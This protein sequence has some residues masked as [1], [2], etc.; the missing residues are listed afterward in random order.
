MSTPIQKRVSRRANVSAKVAEKP[1][2]WQALNEPAV[3]LSEGF[4]KD[5]LL[6]SVAIIAFAWVAPSFSQS[7][8]GSSQIFADSGMV[9]E[10][11][12]VAG[13]QIEAAQESVL[14]ETLVSLPTDFAI[15]FADAA[16]EVL[17]VSEPVGMVVEYYSPGVQA[18][19]DA[20]LYYMKD[21][22]SSW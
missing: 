22:Y 1:T 13:A 3:E 11:G 8:A 14:A 2:V 18:V 16:H 10:I 15:A 17:D 5:V 6:V 7:G 4:A 9:Y 21:P 20:W 12:A 19:T